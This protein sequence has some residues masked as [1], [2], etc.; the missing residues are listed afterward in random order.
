MNR[1]DFTQ[2]IVRELLDYNPETGDLTWKFRD[3]KWFSAEGTWKSWNTKYAGKR[4][5]TERT[6]TNG[7]R[8]KCQKTTLFNK[9]Y[10]S[11]RVIWLWMTGE[12]PYQQ[13]DHIDRDGRNNRWSNLRDVSFGANSRN[14]SLSRRNKS[15]VSGVYWD[16][17]INKWRS[18]VFFDGTE[19]RLGYFEK[20]DLDLAAMEVMEFRAEHGFHPT[21][22]LEHAHYHKGDQK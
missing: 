14:M 7:Y 6:N 17:R 22:G 3:S 8:Y 16:K 2:E 5:C 15:G 21:H 9:A 1:E 4:A 18:Q 13:I 10:L 12:W 20:D 19:Y 11:H